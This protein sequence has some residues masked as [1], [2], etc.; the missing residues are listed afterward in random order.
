MWRRVSLA[1][2]DVSEERVDF[3]FRVK[4]IRERRKVLAVC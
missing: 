1:R 3:I 2:A 4:K